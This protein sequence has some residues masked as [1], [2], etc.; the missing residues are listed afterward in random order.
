[1][2]PPP[3]AGDTG[4]ATCTDSDPAHPITPETVQISPLT[5]RLESWR[6]ELSALQQFVRQNPDLCSF[7]PLSLDAEIDWVLD[8][9]CSGFRIMKPGCLPPPY[10][11]PNYP[12]S[13]L[14][15]VAVAA[16]VTEELVAGRIFEL[17]H[18]PKWST[19]LFA[20]D[21]PGG[22]V[23][24]IR[25]YSINNIPNFKSINTA[26]WNNKFTM[27]CV[28]DAFRLMTPGCFMAKVDI[29]KAFRSVPLHKS[30][31]ELLAF[32]WDGHYYADTRL[33]FGLSNAPEI[34]CRLTS[35]VR[36]M[37]MR[38]GHLAVVAYV[39]D[40]WI[41]A[42]TEHECYTA[43]ITLKEI[44]TDLGFTV[45]TKKSV[46]PTTTLTFLGIE[47]TSDR[48]NNS[49]N[50]MEAR[51]PK[52]KLAQLSDMCGAVLHS[53][54]IS[55]K[56]GQRLLGKLAFVSRVVFAGRTYVRRIIDA[57]TIAERLN[58]R[59]IVTP[60]LRLDFQ[61]WIKFA[62]QFNGKA[63]ILDN[64]NLNPAFFSTDACLTGIG[65][66]FN[67]DYFSCKINKLAKHATAEHKQHRELWPGSRKKSTKDK[68]GYKEL[69]ALWWACVHWG[70]RWRGY[71]ITAHIDNSGVRGMLSTGTCTSKNTE[72]MRLI[73]A[74]FWLMAVHGFRLLPKEI[75]TKENKLSDI[76]SR[77]GPSQ[78]FFDSAAAW[79]VATDAL[80]LHV[81]A[82]PN[83]RFQLLRGSDVPAAADQ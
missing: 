24:T 9:L 72:Y 3:G 14:H 13:P 42:A 51:V 82:P 40:F 33:P 80:P 37:L 75:S 50:I 5:A 16:D 28:D 21:E 62:A 52:E 47:L 73:R 32:L 57:L 18:K 38:R 44:L 19:P 58:T 15:T 66:F 8:G 55:V 76:L 61:F 53:S 67:G 69:F 43:W 25:D 83:Y 71:T 4:G 64:P 17:L 36:L 81:P 7:T 29:S 34:F 56:Y 77:E 74:V 31:W 35:L 46:P 59:V 26:T 60:S 41:C 70:P 1:M 48:D 22:K 65:G 20:K 68:I 11:I 12:L 79:R 23:R 10:H 39:D 6:F 49:S 54:D 63:I 78:L 27:M 2:P 30:H 45:N